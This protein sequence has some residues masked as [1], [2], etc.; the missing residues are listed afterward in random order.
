MPTGPKA[1]LL[2]DRL[3][4]GVGVGGVKGGFLFGA[5]APPHPSPWFLL[6]VLQDRLLHH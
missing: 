4:G 3:Q 5:A 1:L 6:V 2:R